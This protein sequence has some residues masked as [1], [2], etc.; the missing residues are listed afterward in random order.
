MYSCHQSRSA[1]RGYFKSGSLR[2]EPH[3]TWGR[4]R[5]LGTSPWLNRSEGVEQERAGRLLP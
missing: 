5:L 4:E 3:F 2:V 1:S